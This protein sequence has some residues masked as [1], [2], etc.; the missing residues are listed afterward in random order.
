MYNRRLV[1]PALSN[2]LQCKGKC[3]IHLNAKRR[4]FVRRSRHAGDEPRAAC[5]AGVWIDGRN[6]G[7]VIH[8]RNCMRDRSRFETTHICQLSAPSSQASHHH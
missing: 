3:A 2:R 7:T 5:T 1:V 4:A 6:G 8:R